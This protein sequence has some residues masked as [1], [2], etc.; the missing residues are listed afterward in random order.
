MQY[1]EVVLPV[2]IK[3]VCRVPGQIEVLKSFQGK[4]RPRSLG[5]ALPYLDAIQDQSYQLEISVLNCTY[6]LSNSDSRINFAPVSL[7]DSPSSL[8]TG[9][10]SVGP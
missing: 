8:S 10:C 6:R 7:A 2:A 4:W 5:T 1:P 3:T 9:I